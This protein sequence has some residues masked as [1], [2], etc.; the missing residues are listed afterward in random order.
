MGFM[1]DAVDANKGIRAGLTAS[2]SRG[3][4]GDPIKP[5]GRRSVTMMG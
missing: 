2:G 4:S 3:E 5:H 1:L